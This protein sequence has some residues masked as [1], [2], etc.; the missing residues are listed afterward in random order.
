M[1]DQVLKAQKVSAA[2]FVTKFASTIHDHDFVKGSLVLVR[3]SQ[4]EK[5]LNRKTKAHY[6]GPMVVVHRTAGGTYILAEIDS[7]ISRLH[8]A[9]FC[10]VPYFPRS[11]DNLP[12]NSI[13]SATNLDN[14]A[15]HSEDYP[16]ADGLDVSGDYPLGDED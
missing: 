8:Y 10:I 11:L 15:L 7:A 14:I 4:V 2:Q 12:V 3:N 16:L 5:E 13:L 6:L 9:T 1:A